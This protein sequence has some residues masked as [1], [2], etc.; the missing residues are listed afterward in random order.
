[1]IALWLCLLLFTCA[2]AEDKP[3]RDLRVPYE[4]ANR[5]AGLL[6]HVRIN[7]TPVMMIL[8]T[9]S[10]HTII[11]SGIL[12]NEAP[13]IARARPA[14]KGAGFLGDAVGC[15]VQFQIGSWKWERRTVVV[16]DLSALLA[17]YDER[18][19]GVIGLDFM[20]EF[21]T[22]LIDRATKRITFS[23]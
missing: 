16:M 1:M 5:R 15:Q 7:G 21:A 9:G 23:R 2:K 20:D 4:V 12:G 11:Q 14:D 19:K 3:D 18:V 22:I 13:R 6:L 17:A 10:A 8:D